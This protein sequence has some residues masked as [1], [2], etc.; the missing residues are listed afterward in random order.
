MI[1][2]SVGSVL[3][4]ILLSC[5]LTLYLCILLHFGNTIFKHGIRVV[6]LGIILILFRMILPFNFPFTVYIPISKILPEITL[7]LVTP[8]IG[9]ITPLKILVTLWFSVATIKFF[10]LLRQKQSYHRLL[11]SISDI[12]SNYT[13]AANKIV[14]SL[15]G[16]NIRIAIIRRKVSPAITGLFRPVLILPEYNYTEKELFYVIAHEWNHY[17]HF[18]ILIQNLI[19]FL[20]C[21]YWWNPFV[22]VLNQKFQTAVEISNDR[23]IVE[24]MTLQERD[25]YMQ[26]LVKTAKFYQ[27]NDSEQ[28]CIPFI[29]QGTALLTRIEKIQSVNT[30]CNKQN[31]IR[32]IDN[33]LLIAGMV[34]CSYIF[35]PEASKTPDDITE[36]CFTIDP[37]DAYFIKTENGYDLYTENQF[38]GSMEKID[39]T[40][41]NLPVY[42][43][44][45]NERMQ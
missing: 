6:F 5:I 13:Q 4:C 36:E 11:L 24:G 16:K 10:L 40:L 35:I 33:L 7:P 18:D 30:S 27:N 20:T 42:K 9:S 29:G 25:S 43:E 45:P 38:R 32:Q 22:H 44:K 23:L 31:N 21:L 12:E 14:Q 8:V 34:F 3:T 28:F 19:L 17:K 39:E 15:G 41:I 37:D 26:C 2:L 1:Y